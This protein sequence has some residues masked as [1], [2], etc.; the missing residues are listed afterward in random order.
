MAKSIPDVFSTHSAAKFCRVTPMTIIRWIEEGRIK[1]YKT[2]GGHRRI[3]RADL[4]DFCRRSGIPMQ[5]EVRVEKDEARR[6]LI[7]DDNADVVDSILDALVDDGS[8]KSDAFTVEHASNAFDA[9]RLLADFRPDFVFFDV[10]LAGVTPE[11]L[12]AAVRGGSNDVR[13]IAISPD[14]VQRPA[15]F[16]DVLRHPIVRSAIQAITG[17]ITGTDSLRR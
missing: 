5:W 2:P 1:A 13:L 15:Q 17:P 10:T 16:D 6:V 9:G 3:M 14:G 12:A 4:E 11:Q 8:T 7:I